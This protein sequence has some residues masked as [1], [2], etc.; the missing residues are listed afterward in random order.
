MELNIYTSAF[1]VIKNNFDYKSAIDNFLGLVTFKKGNGKVVIAVNKSED[2]SLES[3][4]EYC[5]GKNVKIIDCNISYNNPRLDGLIKDVALQNC[6][7]EIVIG[8]DLDE[9]IPSFQFQTW[10]DYAEYLNSV[11]SIDCIM[12]PSL[13]IYKEEKYVKNIIQKWYLHKKSGLKRG[14]VNFAQYEN[15]HHDIQKS[16]S[17]E[18]VH[19]K[20]DSLAHS[21]TLLNYSEN[22]LSQ[23]KVNN[24]PYVVHY[25]YLDLQR[26]AKLNK[27]FW[28]AQWSLEAGEQVKIKTKLEELED[29]DCLIE[30]G[31]I[32]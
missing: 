14:V 30:H 19:Q 10:Y 5:K 18:L 9:R 8:L 23:I 7:S 12:I 4:T 21:V 28:E 15:G 3:I 16:D 31:L 24:L 11:N 22:I 32:L 27:E 2:N 20:D 29:V 26:R 13:N 6:E 17:C 25:G 1:N